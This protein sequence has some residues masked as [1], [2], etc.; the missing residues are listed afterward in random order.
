[1]S[2]L[3]PNILKHGKV[4]PERL[5]AVVRFPDQCTH[6]RRYQEIPSMRQMK[7][8]KHTVNLIGWPLQI[9]IYKIQTLP[10]NPPTTPAIYELRPEFSH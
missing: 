6:P 10:Q 2:H 3:C 9:P 8:Y 4:G 5:P 7:L 1:M